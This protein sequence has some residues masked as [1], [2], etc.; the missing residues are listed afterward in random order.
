MKAEFLR[1]TSLRDDRWCT[2]VVL[3]TSGH[4]ID[5]IKLLQSAEGRKIVCFGVDKF[6]WF[7]ITTLREAG[8]NPDI[9]ADNQISTLDVYLDNITIVK[10]ETL[11]KDKEQYY[12]IITRE[13]RKI[14]NEI[15]KQLLFW[16]VKDF[17]ILIHDN[18][19]DFDC[20]E[21]KG[22]RSAFLKAFNDIYVNVDFAENNFSD[23]W[24]VF[25]R[26][27]VWWERAFEWILKEYAGREDISLLDVGPGCGLES[28]MYKELLNVSLNWINL[29][30]P[31]NSYMISQRSEFIER[32]K[33]NVMYG[34]IETDIFRGTYDIIIFTDIMEHLVY[35]PISTLKKLYEMLKPSGH[36]ILTTPHK[37]GAGLPFF[38]T[39][40]DMPLFNQD[41]V[42][43]NAMLLRIS[44]MSHVY[45]YS[46]EEVEEILAEA[47][48]RVDYHKYID[49]F[50]RKRM[51]YVCS[52]IE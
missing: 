12:F 38:K 17:A 19:F 29:E 14:V 49:D 50:L 52:K 51:E 21:H 13:D 24:F 9:I 47:G 23:A 5:E 37:K 42:K 18:L 46:P 45:E 31:K 3:F 28:L 11:L 41:T 36:L 25:S 8:I 22:L 43:R 44:Q 27:I 48:F 7:H 1:K 10:P 6:S 16:E 35:N 34:C 4:D 32:N 2:Q 39:W 15:R 40:R 20:S 33:I 30:K 26:P